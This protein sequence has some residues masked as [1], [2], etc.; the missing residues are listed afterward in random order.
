MEQDKDF[1]ETKIRQ[2]LKIKLIIQI[3]QTDNNKHCLL[4]IYSNNKITTKV[5][6]HPY[7]IIFRKIMTLNL[8]SDQTKIKTKSLRNQNGVINNKYKNK[9]IL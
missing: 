5:I 2:K 3:S 1:L 8:F 7:S 6:N 4:T 9:T